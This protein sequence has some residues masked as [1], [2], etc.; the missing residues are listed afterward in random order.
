MCLI[1]LLNIYILLTLIRIAESD[2]LLN[3]LKV[4]VKKVVSFFYPK[5]PSS[6]A[7]TPELLDGMS[8]RCRD[9]ILDNMKQAASLT[10]MILK[11][12][13]PRA[14]FNAAG[15]D[16]AVTCTG[17]EALKLVEDSALMVDRI[18]DMIPIDMS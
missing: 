2:A 9:V 17:E 7:W 13:Y 16:F 3:T 15:D 10:L 6:D 18:V 8:N 1:F 14:D 5:D 11:S 12:L 4:M